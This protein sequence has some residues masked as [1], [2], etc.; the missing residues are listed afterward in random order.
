MLC[1][2]HNDTFLIASGNPGSWTDSVSDVNVPARQSCTSFCS[3]ERREEAQRPAVL[4]ISNYDV[5][6]G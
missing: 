1:Y 5:L 3:L 4:R 2:A 6:I